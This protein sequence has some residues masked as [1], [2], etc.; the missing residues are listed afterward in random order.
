MDLRRLGR[1]GLRVSQ[2]CLGTMTFGQPGWGCA[3]D[4][5]E[6]I[7]EHFLDAGGNFF[8]SADSYAGGQ[9]EEILGRLI[10]SRR[11]EV[12][13]ATKV[14]NHTGSGPN[15]WG[16]SRVHILDALHASLRRLNTDY[17]DLYQ[18]HYYD[19]GTPIEETLGVLHDCVRA[20][21]IRYIGCSNFFAWQLSQAA[22]VASDLGA[23]E[24]ASCQMMYNLVR[25]DLEREHFAACSALGIGLL[26]YSPLHSGVLATGLRAS[27]EPPVGSR[28]SAH[29]R[30]RSVYFG[31]EA[32]VDHVV[33]GLLSVASKF[34]MEPA[35]LA[36]GWVLR[37]PEITSVL[38]G[39]QSLREL[40]YNIG[41]LEL[42]VEEAA[43]QELDRLTALPPSYPQDF[44]T[45]LPWT[46][47]LVGD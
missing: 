35:K 40:E 29:P 44:Y 4:E 9:S 42:D 7:V 14:G 11:S 33:D 39:V 22:S 10:A 16:L 36:L 18:L 8:D 34:G 47:K 13:V 23:T 5:A 2:L 37:R 1:T 25:R 26:T 3:E 28:V 20:G 27:A 32:R 41:C 43:W 6:R 46:L 31:D 15:G 24:F 45:R 12:V 38:T 17:I 30:I 21:K 19:N